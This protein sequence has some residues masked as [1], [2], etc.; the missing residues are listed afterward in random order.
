[1]NDQTSGDSEREQTHFIPPTPVEPELRILDAEFDCPLCG[2]FID[3]PENHDKTRQQCGDC[4]VVWVI[5]SKLV[6]EGT[7]EP[8]RIESVPATP[9]SLPE[10]YEIRPVRNAYRPHHEPVTEVCAP[11]LA[12]RYELYGPNSWSGQD[13][14][15]I[16][17]YETMLA[18]VN[19]AIGREHPP[20]RSIP[21]SEIQQMIDDV[22]SWFYKN[23]MFKTGADGD[24]LA[25]LMVTTGMSDELVAQTLRGGY[26]AA[27]LIFDALNASADA[28]GLGGESA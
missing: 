20:E 13:H 21:V 24:E 26:E 12:D 8:E 25:R 3:D 23:T 19:A 1:M 6:Q 2:A 16:E 11:E 22:F 9:I 18:A 17:D 28:L 4:A 7:P 15:W 5:E 10:G 27:G 14:G